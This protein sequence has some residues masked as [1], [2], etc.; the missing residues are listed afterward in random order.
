[1]KYLD[2]FPTVEKLSGKKA[3]FLLGT[4][5]HIGEGLD[6]SGNKKESETRVGLVPEQV[7]AIKK[8]LE[9]NGVGLDFFFIKGAGTRAD[10]LDSSYLKIGGQVLFEHQLSSMPAPDVVH[11]LKEPCA[12]ET[13]I[14][15]PFLRI[16]ALHSGAFD[17]ESG[18]GF[19]FKKRNFCAIFDGSNIGTD[20]IIPIRGAMSVFA[21]EIAS[22]FAVKNF[23]E[24]G[25]NNVKV[26][27]SGG[28]VVGSASVNEF[29]KNGIDKCE[30][31][32]IVEP[33]EKLVEKLKEKY[34]DQPKI[35]VLKG[36][37]LT[38]ELVNNASAIILTAFVKGQSSPDVLMFNDISLMKN[39]SIIVDV[40]IDERGGIKIDNF[41]KGDFSLAEVVKKIN[42]EIDSL[43]KGIKY[44]ADDHLPKHK[45]KKASIAH[46]EAIMPYVS[47]LLYCSA[48]LGGARQAAKYILTGNF[49]DQYDKKAQ[50]LLQHLKRGLAFYN[51]S[52]IRYNNNIINDAINKTNL[53]DFFNE[54]GI[55]FD[56][57]V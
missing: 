31:I 36:S 48:K 23:I 42:S 25:Q 50:E 14:P 30:E 1:M 49:S 38:S 6:E 54:S 4:D 18:V 47:M 44:I 39:K 27:I 15:S 46:G 12:Y 17:D 20:T 19:L 24:H 7:E 34:T 56:E 53:S 40:S 55:E 29:L 35:K 10:F 2:K 33:N 32:I 41:A 21:G 9:L 51:A 45:P 13:F 52:P 8:W 57:F 26:I 11:A 3:I 43:S 28:G 22:E 37:V 5:Q 16:G